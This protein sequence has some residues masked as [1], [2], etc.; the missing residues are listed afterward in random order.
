MSLNDSVNMGLIDNNNEK[1][2]SQIQNSGTN[3]TRKMEFDKGIPLSFDFEPNEIT[4]FNGETY[5][6]IFI[7]VCFKSFKKPLIILLL[8][9]NLLY[10]IAYLILKEKISSLNIYFVFIP[11]LSMIILEIISDILVLIKS[12]NKLKETNNQTAYFY[13]H[14]SKSFISTSWKKLRVGHIIR[15]NREEIVP[16]DMI[17]LESM[18]VDHL[19]YIDESSITGVFDS[20]KIKTAF[21]DTQTPTLKP[22]KIGEYIKNIKGMLKYEECNENINSFTGRLKLEVFPRASDVTIENFVM[23]GSSIKNVKSV[24]GLVVY[25]G[26][27]CKVM[28]IIKAGESSFISKKKRNIIDYTLFNLQLVLI[29]IF[30]IFVINFLV[31]EI[32]KLYI[33]KDEQYKYYYFEISDWWEEYVVSLLQFTFSIQL[34]I[35]YI[36]FN[37]INLGYEICETLISWDAK[38]ILKSSNHVNIIHNDCLAKFGQV[39]YILADKTGTLTK[40]RFDIKSCYVNEKI[41]SLEFSEMKDE[42]YIFKNKDEKYFEKTEIFK[43]LDHENKDFSNSNKPIIQLLEGLSACHQIKM[44]DQDHIVNTNDDSFIYNCFAEEKAIVKTLKTLGYKITKANRDKII[45]NINNETKIFYVIGR[46]LYSESR[47]RMSVIYK[48][49]NTDNDSYMICKGT[50]ASM[51]NLINFKTEEEKQEITERIKNMYNLGY[52]YFIYGKKY[53]FDDDTESYL[54]KYKSISNN[55]QKEMLSEQL[56]NEYENDLDFLG[57]LFFEEPYSPDL[58][59]CLKKLEDADIKTWI[60]SGDRRDN[61]VAV[62]KNL[63]MIAPNSNIVEF[64]KEDQLVDLDVKMNMHLMQFIYEGDES[65]KSS[66]DSKKSNLLHMYIDGNILNTI[67]NDSRLF[68]SFTILLAYT[69]RVFGYSFCSHS[70]YK[71]TKIMQEYVCKNSKLL[72]IGDGLNDTMMLREANLSIGIRSKEVLQLRNNCDIIVNKFEQITDLIL[73]HGT[74]INYRI[75]K[76]CTYSVYASLLVIMQYYYL[77]TDSIIGTNFPG[78]SYLILMIQFLILNV[79]IILVICFDQNIDRSTISILPGIYSNNYKSQLD[80]F[81]DFIIEIIKSVLH[82]LIIYY[83]IKYESENEMN[84]FGQTSDKLKNELTIIFGS[85]FLIYIRL[86]FVDLRLI[87]SISIFTILFSYVAMICVNLIYVDEYIVTIE[88][89]GYLG[90]LLAFIL[91]TFSCFLFEF[92]LF[93]FITLFANEFY[94]LSLYSILKQKIEDY[95]FFDNMD[96]NIKTLE[97]ISEKYKKGKEITSFISVAKNL[98]KTYGNLDSGIDNSKIL[99]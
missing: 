70:K 52:R 54:T 56:A 16:A 44:K 12:H 11:Q 74:W 93:N 80:Y 98:H 62:S 26:M 82:S 63:K 29:F 34:F 85:Y 58:K 94:F 5:I 79:S 2:N 3:L 1:V 86:L 46:N 33:S 60:I 83:G 27:E 48:K 38:V 45:V 97:S 68:Q 43:D 59:F 42:D 4:I 49:R 76:I 67:C 22:M 6:N 90:T 23:R 31:S 10:L 81:F 36:W 47:K 96:E 51:V 78:I 84:L 18:D 73:V 87:S 37:M 95:S 21:I 14:D 17:I 40:R 75:T 71:F 35:P 65:K 13:D 66:F 57:I 77:P 53:L 91:V 15:V 30:F 50:D 69:S 8:F 7:Q 9:L 32:Q 88:V 28:Q 64:K 99:N 89:F 55:G 39:K 72:A 20:Y 92:F 24:Y 19:C 41:Y 61:V 25:T